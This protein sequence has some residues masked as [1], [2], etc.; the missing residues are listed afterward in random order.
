[1]H[2]DPGAPSDEFVESD[3]EQFVYTL[4]SLS[5]TVETLAENYKSF[6]D[7][8]HEVGLIHGSPNRRTV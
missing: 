2:N 5:E 1:L 7:Y 6:S 4:D 8:L 3:Q